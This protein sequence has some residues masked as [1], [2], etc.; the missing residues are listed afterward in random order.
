M[1][2]P[3]LSDQKPRVDP[4]DGLRVLAADL[5]ALVDRLEL[6][7]RNHNL[8]PTLKA[9][10][11]R[12]SGPRAVVMLLSE[13][14][15]L[16]RRFL[17]R[18]LGPKLA[19][20]P[21]ATTGCIRLEY[22]AAPECNLNDPLGQVIRLPNPT[23]KSGL[24]VIDTPA[25]E[26]GEQAASVLGCA[27]QADA[28]IFVLNADH[29]LSEASGA[30]LRRL[31]ENGARLEIVIENADAL[32]SE[33]RLAARNRLLE[34]L[35]ERCNIEM[36]R[37]T[38]VASAATESGDASFW[39]GR[40][41][42]FHSVMMLRGRAH[43]LEV[44]RTMVA[45]ALTK[46]AA[47]IDFELKSL[48]PGLR[49]TRLRLGMKDLDGLRARFDGLARVESERPSE[50]AANEATQAATERETREAGEERPEISGAMTALAD[51]T[52]LTEPG[53]VSPGLA[54]PGF[55]GFEGL[56]ADAHPQPGLSG[57]FLSGHSLSGHFN[58]ELTGLLRPARALLSKRV[59]RGAPAITL[60]CLIAGLIV[61]ALSPRGFFFGREAGAEWDYHLP[62]PVP[63]DHP[64]PA[65][66]SQPK[67]DLPRPGD[68][69]LLPG[70]TAPARPNVAEAPP[71]KRRAAVRLPLARPIPTGATA[72][73]PPPAR[74]HHHHLLG[75]GKLW[76]WVRHGRSKHASTTE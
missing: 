64:A 63:T 69:N 59:S 40:F 31:P 50:T 18:L 1:T 22:G 10:E 6:K 35:R 37:L 16:K 51:P 53:L 3:H 9:I 47:E 27:E 21:K 68:A 19:Q 70:P 39:H 23:L 55:I 48:A 61:W 26:G 52:S 56:A 58:E 5:R 46:V 54:S 41:A 67:V 33:E 75:L 73:A 62:K 42:T 20:V 32:S 13:H 2:S 15:Q 43:W 44:T 7:A 4:V 11:Q 57:H 12:L 8:Q 38:L 24:A 36:P 29:E 25:L 72:G 76:H 60:L 49:H 45:D 34:T 71:A 30:L 17:E 28:C 14:E 74:R 65:I 66:A